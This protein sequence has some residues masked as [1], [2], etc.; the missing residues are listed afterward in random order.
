LKPL[1][2]DVIN[3]RVI[4]VVKER[5]GATTEVESEVR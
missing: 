3:G 1:S 5:S 4:P 2:F